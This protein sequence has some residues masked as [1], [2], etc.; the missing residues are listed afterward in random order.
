MDRILTALLLIINA[1]HVQSISCC[2]AHTTEVGCITE[3][4]SICTWL[5]NPN[6]P[7]VVASNNVQCLDQGYVNCKLQNINAHCS[8]S[9][10]SPGQP[11]PAPP[12][13]GPVPTLSPTTPIPTTQPTR[14]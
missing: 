7:I 2:P 5:T 9:S 10:N 14:E 8:S 11:A 6:D 1:L 12:I 13:C 4:G 3:P